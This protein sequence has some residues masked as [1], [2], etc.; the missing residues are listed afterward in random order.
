MKRVLCIIGSMDAGGAETFLMKLLRNLD[1]SQYCMDFCVNQE[2]NLYAGEIQALGGRIYVVPTKSQ[3]LLKCFRATRDLVR[4]QGYESV[5]RVNEHSLSVL[6]LLAARAGGAK[7]LIMRSSNASSGSKKSILLHRLFKFL[8]MLVPDVKI[9]PSE[10]AAEYTFGKRAVRKHQ[11]CKL[12]NALDLSLF[13]FDAEKRTRYRADLGLEDKLVIGHVGRFNEQKN[14]DFL[15]DVFAQFH[16]T[17]VNSVLVLIG[18]GEL[19]EKI[20]QKAKDLGIAESVRF[21]G[22]RRDVPEL[23]CA[24]DAFLFPSFYEGMPNTVIEAQTTGLPCL[25]SDRITPEARVTDLVQFASLDQTP[26][27]WAQQLGSM[28]EKKP[29]D[30]SLAAPKMRAEGYDIRS[31]AER[32]QQLVF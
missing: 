28:A 14:H 30:R 22:V 8:P 18:N 32:F 12:P 24:M 1:R 25:I 17:H 15:L 13:A 21:L 29:A 4:S 10:L 3:G 26:E 16:K 19:E 6:D 2:E 31:C 11:V 9:A 7:K 23:L 5:M 20:R 27:H